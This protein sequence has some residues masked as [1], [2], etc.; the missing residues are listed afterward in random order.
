V[1]H[2]EDYGHAL[3]GLYGDGNARAYSIPALKEIASMKVDDV[4]D[5]RRFSDALITT[6]GDI[7]GWTGPAELVFVNVLGSGLHKYVKTIFFSDS[8]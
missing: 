6:H 2:H 8:S 4:M 3:I 5:R 1:L 7:I